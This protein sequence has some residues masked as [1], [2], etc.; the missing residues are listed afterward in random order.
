VT[1]CLVTRSGIIY[2]EYTSIIS[3]A[4]SLSSKEAYKEAQFK[5]WMKRMKEAARPD[6]WV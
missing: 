6:D 3:S 4:P 1:R 5:D 2:Y